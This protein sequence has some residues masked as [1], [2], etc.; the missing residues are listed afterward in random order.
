MTVQLSDGWITLDLL[1][2]L[3]GCVVEWDAMEGL[4]GRTWLDITYTT[5][6]W[7]DLP[8]NLGFI[9]HSITMDSSICSIRTHIVDDDIC[10]NLG[11]NTSSGTKDY[12]IKE[13]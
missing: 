4:P 11:F 3:E 6:T 9:H 8:I 7:P 10:G 1:G 2:T 13:D 5:A 12:Y